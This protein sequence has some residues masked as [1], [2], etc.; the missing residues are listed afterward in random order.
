[1]ATPTEARLILEK[2]HTQ[3]IYA[4]ICEARQSLLVFT[5]NLGR[6]AQS[7][8]LRFLAEPSERLGRNVRIVCGSR[9]E[10]D[11][12]SIPLLE[13]LVKNGATL[14][15]RSGLNTNLVVADANH[16]VL[17]GD[18]C[19]SGSFAERRSYA[20]RIGMAIKGEQIRALILPSSAF[21][22]RSAFQYLA[23]CTW[24]IAGS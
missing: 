10:V 8:W 6:F 1:M 17:L 7:G 15:H 5:G 24:P 12:S 3:A 20:A 23:P 9:A 2:D 18:G 13:G 16:I 11:I 22:E 14:E 19:E 21:G 4:A